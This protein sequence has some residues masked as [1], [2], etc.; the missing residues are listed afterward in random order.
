VH[1]DVIDIHDRS[2][3][4]IERGTRRPYPSSRIPR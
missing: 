3:G 2:P 1:E 4:N